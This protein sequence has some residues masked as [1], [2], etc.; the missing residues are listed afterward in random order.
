MNDFL[1]FSIGSLR[2][3]SVLIALLVIVIGI[4]LVKLIVRAEKRVLQKSRWDQSLKDV[5]VLISRFV[6]D[7]VVVVVALDYLGIPMTSVI[8]VLGVVGLA[9]SLAI[10]DT[11]ANMFAGMI[12]LA[13][14]V[15]SSGDYVQ[16]GTMEGTVI[17]VDLMNTHLRTADNKTIRIPNNDVQTSP[18]INFSRESRRRVE[19]RVDVSYNCETDD[20][21]ASLL[22]AA[23]EV[24]TVLADPA[25]FAGLFA[26][27]N[28]GIEFVL[29]VWSESA[30]YW[31]TY[32]A[33]TE[34]VRRHFQED[35]IEMTYD[36]IN[37]HMITD[38]KEETT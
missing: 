20:V 34:G 14:K 9:V 36:H 12:L 38:S 22:R 27:K 29:R 25:P 33:L 31:D 24:K 37:V 17:K 28:S 19:L 3:E 11:L 5:V 30:D 7:A 26:F 4:L 23:A 10:Q 6:L 18:I 21:K 35:G 15:I 32:Y 16:L 13:A 2:M 1:Q 8:T